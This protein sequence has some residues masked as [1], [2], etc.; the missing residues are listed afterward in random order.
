MT[1]TCEIR[2]NGGPDVL[3]WIDTEP[4]EPG[5]GEVR[6][7]HHA[8]GLNYI[9]IYHRTGLYPLSLP[10]GIGLEAAGEITA[11]GDGVTDLAIGDRVAYASAP[12][13]AYAEE[14]LMPADRVVPL[15]DAVD[16]RSAAALMLKGLT[17]HFLLFRTF[18]IQPGQRVLVHAAA[19]GVGYLLCTWATHLGATVIGTAGSREKA[20]IAREAGCAEVIQYRDGNIATQ[21]RRAAGKRGVDVVYDG[22]GAATFQDS[23]DSLA[24]LGMMVSFGNASGPV[25]AFEPS[26]LARRGSLFFTRPSLLDYTRE[27]QDLLDGASALFDAVE[28]GI[29][30]AR[31]GQEFP[32]PEAAR[33]HRA[34]EARK[35]TGAS[36]LIPD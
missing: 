34:L 27:R 22:V 30:S 25:P 1:L 26:E 7:R 36:L 28:A 2:R 29:L 12:L 5:P 15:P 11:I 31:I 9:D 14:R 24:P 4:G 20:A 23:L 19:G 8:V 6:I 33:A 16:A 13:G 3:E 21:V 18:A 35:T 32:L 10:S 17:A